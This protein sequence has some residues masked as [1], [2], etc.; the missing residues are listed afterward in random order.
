MNFNLTQRKSNQ[1]F[2]FNLS[3]SSW[4]WIQLSFMYFI[5]FPNQTVWNDSIT[6][7]RSI[8][9]FA[10]VGGSVD[11]W[12]KNYYSHMN[13]RLDWFLDVW[14][15]VCH[16]ECAL[17]DLS[18]LVLQE[19]RGRFTLSG[20]AS[21]HLI[22][23]QR[24]TSLLALLSRADFWFGI[25]KN[26]HEHIKQDISEDRTKDVYNHYMHYTWY[27]LFNSKFTFTPQAKCDF[28]CCGAEV[29][30]W[31]ALK[32][33]AGNRYSEPFNLIHYYF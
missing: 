29:L 8:N 30:A 6:S 24:D 3:L 33:G 31:G 21:I 26:K 15:F 20:H 22:S 1:S 5:P 17:L 18:C 27:F 11:Q 10:F 2:L 13:S 9:L 12:Y 14:A 4:E 19:P 23:A 25:L 32:N 28:F 16:N 7:E